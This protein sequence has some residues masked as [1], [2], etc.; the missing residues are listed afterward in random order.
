MKTEG[1][2]ATKETKEAIVQ[3][4]EGPVVEEKKKKREEK[5]AEEEG[6][7]SSIDLLMEK[8]EYQNQ[9]LNT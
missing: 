3:A 8:I 5:I 7:A 2:D 4:L 9:S 1:T 6:L